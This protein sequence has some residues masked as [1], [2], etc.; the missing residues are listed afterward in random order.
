L[1]DRLTLQFDQLIDQTG[2]NSRTC[3]DPHSHA[4]TPSLLL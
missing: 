2:I 1:F 4:R 3:V